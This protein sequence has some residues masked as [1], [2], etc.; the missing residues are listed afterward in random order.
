MI[1]IAYSFLNFGRAFGKYDPTLYETRFVF[2]QAIH[3]MKNHI[4][5]TTR[6]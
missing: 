6:L 4:F 2:P 1:M 5:F 3:L